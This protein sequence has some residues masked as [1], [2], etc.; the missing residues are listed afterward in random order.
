MD[1]NN[2]NFQESINLLE[3]DIK[4]NFNKFKEIR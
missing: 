1:E 3:I 2:Y 4:Q